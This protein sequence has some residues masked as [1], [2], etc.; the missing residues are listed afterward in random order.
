MP[1]PVNMELTA[2]VVVFKPDRPTVTR[3]LKSLKQALHFLPPQLVKLTIVDNSP[4]NADHIWLQEVLGEF[5]CEIISGQGN[6]GFARANNLVLGNV[7]KYHLVLNPDVEME[8][9]AL[10]QALAF[11][12]DNDN[13]ALLTPQAFNPD[14]SKQYLCKRYPTLFD[15][16]LRGFAPAWLKSSFRKRLDRYEMRDR[17]ANA[18]AWDPPIVS[19]CFMLFRGE[20]FEK[21]QGFDPRYLLYFED[22]DISLRTGEIARIAYV[23]SV[24]IVHE[25]GRA[26]DKGP[27]HIWQFMRSAAIFFR[28]HSMKIF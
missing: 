20:V 25:G 9:D 21:L 5:P 2:C 26:A 22:F 10:E 27:W 19:G 23:P 28:Q 8:A 4:G 15:L 14:G 6:V 7:G 13:C 1:E 17:P 16:F 24:Q 18:I 3:T 12:R 11:M